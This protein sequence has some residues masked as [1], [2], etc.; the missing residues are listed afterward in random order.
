M[1]DST[2]DETPEEFCSHCHRRRPGVTVVGH[3]EAVSGPGWLVLA[4]PDC[5]P[6]VRKELGYAT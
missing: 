4:C 2:P 5:T 1:T 3:I 6:A